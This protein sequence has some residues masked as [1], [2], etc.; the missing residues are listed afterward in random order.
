MI[1]AKCVN[2]AYA[3]STRADVHRKALI[4]SITPVQVVTTCATKLS[5]RKYSNGTSYTSILCHPVTRVG[6]ESTVLKDTCTL[7]HRVNDRGVMGASTS[8][9][10]TCFSQHK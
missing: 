9:S 8:A 4:P 6:S 5:G 3:V 7:S 10:W 2:V 1:T